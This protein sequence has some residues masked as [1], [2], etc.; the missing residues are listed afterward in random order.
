MIT[1]RILGSGS[2][3]AQFMKGTTVFAFEQCTFTVWKT[4]QTLGA[5]PPITWPYAFVYRL[6]DCIG[7]F[8]LADHIHSAASP[9]LSPQIACVLGNNTQSLSMQAVTVV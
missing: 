1:L 4:R 6:V 8:V 2:Y 3:I 7:R 9:K 5:R